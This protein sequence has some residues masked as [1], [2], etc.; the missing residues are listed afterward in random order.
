[1]KE[2]RKV[3][4][5][6]LIR[7]TLAHGAHPTLRQFGLTEQETQELA[8]EELVLIG[9]TGVGENLDRYVIAELSDKAIV[10]LARANAHAKQH[11]VS[12]SPPE[13]IPS[14]I[15]R[16]LGSKL[17]DLFWDVVKVSCGIL[18]GWFLKK[19]LP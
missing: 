18:L 19:Y 14:K 9:D 12:H 8:A 6:S 15:A 7:D 2:T 13:S 1:M 11:I 3:E 10:W 17:W 4:V 16:G 5:L